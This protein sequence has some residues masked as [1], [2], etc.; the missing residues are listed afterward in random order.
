MKFTTAST[1]SQ[2]QL[3]RLF[4]MIRGMSDEQMRS[5]LQDI[6]SH[7]YPFAKHFKAIADYLDWSDEETHQMADVDFNDR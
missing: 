1:E 6:A 3:H 4:S 2:Q 5:R 7:E